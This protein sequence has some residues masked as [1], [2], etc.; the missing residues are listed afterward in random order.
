MGML[1]YKN[2]SN[3]SN[4]SFHIGIKKVS[5]ST[6]KAGKSAVYAASRLS[7]LW[8][9][10]LFFP[11][12]DSNFSSSSPSFPQSS[13]SEISWEKEPENPENTASS[14]LLHS[15]KKSLKKIQK[16]LPLPHSHH[17]LRPSILPER[18]KKIPETT[19]F[20]VFLRGLGRKPE[21]KK[22]ERDQEKET[23]NKLDMAVGSGMCRGAGRK[24]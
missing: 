6:L 18:G 12:A 3:G 20:Q 11:Y 13:S 16:R 21:G 10:N 19:V 24:P 7:V 17:H 5:C 23:E 8:S 2:F 1:R 22:P 15:Q 14:T 9:Q 4:Q